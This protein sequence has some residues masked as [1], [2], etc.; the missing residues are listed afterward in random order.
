M[1]LKKIV[2]EIQEKLNFLTKDSYKKAKKY[3]EQDYLIKKV[4]I[5]VDK[6]SLFL[7]NDGQVGV[8][9]EYKIPNTKIYFNDDGEI[10]K[11]ETFYAIN[12]LDL[13]TKEDMQKISVF[14]EDAKIRNKK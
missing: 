6:V 5:K 2:K 9:V 4:K 10:I 7:N 11:N 14:L 1:R 3:E 8:N 13:I 12:T